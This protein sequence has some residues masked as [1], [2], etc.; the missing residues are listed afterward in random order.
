MPST[1]ALAPAESSESDDTNEQAPKRPK[2][3]YKRKRR[4]KKT[5]VQPEADASQNGEVNGIPS[6][7][8]DWIAGKPQDI[9]EKV[10]EKPP[11]C[12]PNLSADSS[13]FDAFTLYFDEE[14][15]TII[16]TETNRYADQVGKANWEPLSVSELKAYIGMLILMSIHPLPQVYLY[17]SSDQLFNVK[18]ISRVM[19]FKRYQQITS[20]LH[21]ND[22]TQQPERTSPG[23]DR[24]Y[25][26]RPL[27]EALNKNFR[28]EY[29]PSSH[30]A[31]DE[32]MILFKGR[33][34]MKQYMPMKP[35]IKRGYKVWSLADSETGYLC[36][37]E[38]Y[39]GR[40][41]ERPTDQ[42][43]GEHVVLSLTEDIVEEGSQVFFDNFFSSTKL[44][45][46]I[47][48]RGVFA[49]GTF[50]T[51]KRDLPPEVKIDN[52]LS[53]GE[54]LYRSKGPVSAYQW[55]DTKNVHM[56][57]NFHDPEE[58][59]SMERKLPCGKKVQVT[60]PMSVKDYNRWMGGVDCFDQKRNAYPVDR[61]SKKWWHR[62]FYFLV[63]AAIVNAFVQHKAYHSDDD[64]ALLHF[65]VLLGRQLIKRHTFR[66][67]RKSQVHFQRKQGRRRGSL[68]TG[69]PSE[70]RLEGRDHFPQEN[71]KRRRCRW[72]STKSKEARTRYV[73]SSCDVPLCVGCFSSFHLPK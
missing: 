60:C 69:V 63:D 52:K 19:T 73:C 62:I 3:T 29:S 24:C 49:C 66:T 9:P 44:L 57:S 6:P 14:V 51:N 27:I 5:P 1:S 54:Y 31:V 10:T 8:M 55:R 26:V 70:I 42:T 64:V 36:R 23:Y 71:A 47:R 28:K 22:N 7:S 16:V 50:R 68:I 4:S 38:V 58:Q 56:M 41:G 35:K 72:C 25:K 17:W 59:A 13:A 46:Q 21:L 61:R 20:C 18:E 48:E 33:S 53:R 39:Q 43:L 65:K 67:A 45:L 15:W 11:T 32:S 37:F 2:K 30:V 40:N 12:S 34:A